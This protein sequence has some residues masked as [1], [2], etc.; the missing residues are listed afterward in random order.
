MLFTIQVNRSPTG[1]LAC[2]PAVMS[3]RS[4]QWVSP[5]L[6]GARKA[7]R[8]SVSLGRRF[9]D[10]RCRGSARQQASENNRLEVGEEHVSRTVQTCCRPTAPGKPSLPMARRSAEHRNGQGGGAICER[11][12]PQVTAQVDSQIVQTPAVAGGTA[13]CSAAASAL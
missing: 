3:A 2:F 13:V 4:S 1:I 9:V 12:E 7:T 5:R 11:F 8:P 6:Q 10:C